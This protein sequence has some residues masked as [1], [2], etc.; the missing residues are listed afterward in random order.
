LLGSIPFMLASIPLG[1][2]L[3]RKFEVFLESRKLKRK[4]RRGR[5]KIGLAA[6][7]K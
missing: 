4:Q 5:H 2:Y 6:A 7:N 1:L 3:G